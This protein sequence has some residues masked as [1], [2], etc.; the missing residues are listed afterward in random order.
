[1][2]LY[3]NNS[4]SSDSSNSSNSSDSSGRS[5]SCDSCQS[6]DSSDK[7]DKNKKSQGINPK[8]IKNNKIAPEN[9]SHF[10]FFSSHNNF[11]H[12]ITI[13]PKKSSFT[14]KCMKNK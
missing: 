14:K 3:T 8:Q 9:F 13:S 1:M 10:V 2:I 5:D 4:D 6:C 11:S 12:Q 7:S